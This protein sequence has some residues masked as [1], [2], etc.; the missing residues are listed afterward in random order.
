MNANRAVEELKDIL[1]TETVNPPGNE[2]AVAKKLETLFTEY[3]IETEL[4]PHSEGRIN[5][6]ATLKGDGSSDYVLGLSGHMDV[7]PPGD[8]PWDYEPFAAK[9]VDGQIYARGACD[10]K[11]GLMACVIA[12][13]QMKEEGVPLSGDVKLLASVGE[14]V[15]AV[16]AQQLTNEGYTE[17]LNA[18]IIA[19]P[20]N[21][22]VTVTHKGALWVEIICYGKTA[23][24][25]RPHKG[26]NAILHMNAVINA[27]ENGR[28]KMDD[29]EDSFLGKPSFSINAIEAGGSPNM[30][31]DMCRAVID[32]RTVPSQKHEEILA[33]IHRLLEALKVE[34]P[35]LSGE[36]Q[37]LNDLPPMETAASDPFVDHLLNVLEKETGE[38]KE[39]TGM[40]GYTDGSQF[41]KSK[42]NFPII[43]WSAINGSTAHQPN[44]YV[45]VEDYL[46][47]IDLFKK[48][49]ISYVGR[50]A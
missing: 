26:T 45:E 35:E 6:I 19:E 5:L 31:P 17:D 38:R 12:L 39:P 21:G 37:V 29:T 16:G 23:H 47:S 44:E 20:T 49:A 25:S 7:V 32:F 8:N 2:E 27:L 24:G 10:M 42:S 9:E 48:I 15:G 46:C 43:I 3:G 41:M 36:V 30:V 28:L 18:L 4:V 13:I 34:V 1:Q 11:S 33:E 22:N 14:E 40:S 50:K